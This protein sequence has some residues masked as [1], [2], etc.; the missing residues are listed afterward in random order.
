MGQEIESSHFRH[1]DF[2]RF[3]RHL[4]DE[5]QL[6]A[7]WFDEQRFV[8]GGLIGGFE[9][10]VWIVDEQGRPAPV[11]ERYLV[12]AQQ[13]GL[14]VVSE[15]ASFNLELNSSPRPLHGDALS[16]MY[17]E[18]NATW[19]Q[20][21]LL[22]QTLNCRLMMI[23]I[24]PMVTES[25]L[26]LG[27]MSQVRRYKALNEQVLRMRQGRPL[28]LDIA[29]R[30]H[31]CTVHRDVMT[32]AATTSFQLHLQVSQ[33]QAAHYYNLARLISAPMVALVANSPF[34][35][36][37][38]LWDETRIPLFEQS[39]AVGGNAG[40]GARVTFGDAYVRSSLFECFQRNLEGYPV[41]LPS[42]MG[43]PPERL[44]HVRLHNGTIW[45]WNRPLI[46]FEPDG[47]PHL[48]LEHRVVPAG[49]TVADAIAN[50]AFFFGVM[51]GLQRLTGADEGIDFATARSNFYTAARLGLRAEIAWLDKKTV[52]VAELLAGNLLPLAHQGLNAL[53][54]DRADVDNFLAI[55]AG[56]LRTG[57]NGAAWQRAYVAKHGADFQALTLAYL[58]HQNRGAPVHEWTI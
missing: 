47:R 32:E 51:A 5:T 22:A 20:C 36:G 21:D 49:P 33:A 6:L 55:I 23:G 43:E 24:S 1:K 26:S 7:Q 44:A 16:A 28:Q 11:N 58:E 9:L 42:V 57:Q 56:R 10:E 18:L 29:G 50:A 15:L 53:G 25:Q 2:H 46:G 54:V 17:D 38:D 52:S 39:V 34:L 13:Q 37:C 19:R 30:E 40:G 8:D 45:R 35:F 14:P 12:L 31:L 27:N 3:K 4:Q 41:L 48:R